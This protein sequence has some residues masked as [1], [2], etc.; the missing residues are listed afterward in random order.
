[1][2]NVLLIGAGLAAVG[3]LTWFL[4]LR[5]P[6]A[7]IAAAPAA[8]PTG[9][10]CAA[11]DA[12]VKVNTVRGVDPGVAA[13]GAAVLCGS[14]LTPQCQQHQIGQAASPLLAQAHALVKRA[15]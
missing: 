15:L 3:G 14:H 10:P 13:A 8:H 9:G 12:C 7:P 4:F 1:M 5:K 11:F 6:P 2:R